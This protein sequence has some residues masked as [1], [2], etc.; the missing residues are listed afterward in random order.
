MS[1]QIKPVLAR[2]MEVCAGFLSY[3]DHHVGRLID[4]IDKLGILDERLIYVIIGDNGASAESNFVG[5]T[6]EG[7]TINHL[8]E[9]ETEEYLVEHVQ[10][11]GAPKSYNHY[12]IGWVHRVDRMGPHRSRG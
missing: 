6:N 5:T 7:F 1:A 9:L 11:I 12:A 8:N 2:E 3:A 10:D 4:A